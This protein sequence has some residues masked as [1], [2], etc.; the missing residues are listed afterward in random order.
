MRNKP[1]KARHPARWAKQIK[2]DM[3]V[4][5]RI[6]TTRGELTTM[7][8][9]HNRDGS[10]T[11]LLT[12]LHDDDH[13]RRVYQFLSMMLIATDS[14]GFTMMSEAW[15]SSAPPA[16]PGES[17]TDVMRR[18][19]RDGPMP[20][21]VSNREEVVSIAVVYRDDADDRHVISAVGG[22]VRGDD[23]KVTALDWRKDTGDFC[24]G[25]VFNIMPPAMPRPEHRAIAAHAMADIG[26]A[27]M[28]ALGIVSPG[29]GDG[30]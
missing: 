16:E 5:G 18:V 3:T 12:P 4:A 24:D 22:I 7:F 25:A 29:G 21:Q 9:L 27:I 1:N 28:K 8:V 20:R 10:F 17:P 6:I 19:E 26:P 30:S 14:P 15:Q 2:H 11:P 13:K 23:A